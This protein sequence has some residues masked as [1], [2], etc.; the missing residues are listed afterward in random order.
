MYNALDF[1]YKGTETTVLARLIDSGVCTASAA[2]ALGLLNREY[3]ARQIADPLSLRRV[4]D[5]DI[6]NGGAGPR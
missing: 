6:R 3:T 5:G 4:P 2:N 1:P